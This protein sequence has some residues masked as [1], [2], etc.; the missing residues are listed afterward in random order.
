M[1]KYFKDWECIGR[2][3]RPKGENIQLVVQR[4]GLKSPVYVGD[5]ILDCQAA[6]QA[7][8]PFIHASYGFGEVPDVERVLDPIQL[9]KL[10]EE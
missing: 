9:L 2:T 3:G 1:H 7:G 8:V 6:Q 5:T 4:N 10:L